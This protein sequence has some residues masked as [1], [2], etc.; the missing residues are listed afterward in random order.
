MRCASEV[1]IAAS[2]IGH[3]TGSGTHGVM[4]AFLFLAGLAWS[5][6]HATQA[7]LPSVAGML[8]RRT[9]LV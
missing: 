5:K 1:G 8:F 2:T 4:D 9:V 6:D 3:A 7:L